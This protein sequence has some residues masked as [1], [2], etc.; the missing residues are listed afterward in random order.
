MARKRSTVVEDDAPVAAEPT[1]VPV[2]PLASGDPLECGETACWQRTPVSFTDSAAG[3]TA[4]LT[5]AWPGNIVWDFG[6][7][8]DPVMGRGPVD[9]TYA[10]AGTYTVTASPVASACLKPGTASVTV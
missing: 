3:L 10:G 1:G 4:T 8:T 5:P 7:G 9:H 6:D 2:A